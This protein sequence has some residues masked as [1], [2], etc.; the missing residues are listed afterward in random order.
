MTTPRQASQL[1]KSYSAWRSSRLGRITDRLE[2]DLVLDLLGAASAKTVLDVGCGDGA[3]SSELARRGGTVT[4]L[5]ADAIMI[6]SAQ[7]R[8]QRERARFGLVLGSAE[9]LPFHD[10]AFDLVVAVTMLCFLRNAEQAVEEMARV[11]KPGGRLVIGE[12]GR[13]SLWAVHR[14]MRGWFG[15][16]VWRAVRFRTAPQ[17]RQ[18]LS[19]AGLDVTAVRGAVYYPPS[20]VM[21]QILAPIDPWLGRHTTVG[22]AFIALSAR[23]P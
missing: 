21:A 15:N 1:T 4:G 16:P 8:A 3:F 7:E 18:L 5:D 11:L 23:K 6:G 12:L 22:A 17:L 10:A 14:R 9:H 2:Q 19:A 20:G 13:V